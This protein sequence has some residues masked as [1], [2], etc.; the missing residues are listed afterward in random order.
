MASSIINIREISETRGFR[1]RP[2]VAGLLRRK[3]PLPEDIV[4]TARLVHSGYRKTDRVEALKTFLGIALAIDDVKKQT[5]GF[6]APTTVSN[7]LISYVAGCYANE[8]DVDSGFLGQ[9]E[10]F[11]S[12]LALQIDPKEKYEYVK[13]GWLIPKTVIFQGACRARL[14][15]FEV[16]DMISMQVP[17]LAVDGLFK[18][19]SDPKQAN[20]QIFAEISSMRKYGVKTVVFRDGLL[21]VYGMDWLFSDALMAFTGNPATDAFARAAFKGVQAAISVVRKGIRPSEIFS[22]DNRKYS[23]RSELTLTTYEGMSTMYLGNDGEVGLS[24]GPGISPLRDLFASRGTTELYEYFRFV[25]LMR[26]FDLVVPVSQVAKMPS[27]PSA[28]STV[29]KVLEM[30]GISKKPMDY[31]D[32]LLPRVRLLESHMPEI[33]SDLRQEVDNSEKDTLERVHKQHAEHV[34][35]G[36]ARPLPKGYKVSKRA[37]ELAWEESK[38]ILEPGETYVRTHRRGKGPAKDALHKARRN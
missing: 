6:E 36:F 23:A 1:F 17:S 12:Q 24:T 31:I 20:D 32:I 8:I 33:V 7:L 38:I 3:N 35:I 25:Q 14:N 16:L 9:I 15:A 26:F 13:G 11:A 34:V 22:H 28:P 4:K 29:G 30:T 37:R 27:L 10:D 19:F 5:I 21:N 2:H 18:S